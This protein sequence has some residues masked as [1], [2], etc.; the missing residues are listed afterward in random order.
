MTTQ[1]SVPKLTLWP[2]V[3]SDLL[4]VCLA[5]GLVAWSR[6]P[7][8]WVPALAATFCVF[9]G[10]WFSCQP[11][12]KRLEI[13]SKLAEHDKLA[14]TL[15]QIQSL[16]AASDLISNATTQWQSLREESQKTVL[17]ARE[18]GERMAKEVQTFNE[19]WQKTNDLEK[20][21][22]RLELEKLKRQEGDWL[23]AAIRMLDHVH[24]LFA[25]ALRSSQPTLIQ[26]LGQFQNVCRDAVRRVG[27]NVIWPESG[28]AFDPDLHQTLE[29]EDPPAG[30]GCIAEVLAAGYAFQ[31]QLV[32]KPLVR[33]K[34]ANAPE[35]PSPSDA[36]SPAPAREEVAGSESPVESASPEVEPPA[37]EPLSDNLAPDSPGPTAEPSPDA[38]PSPPVPPPGQEQELF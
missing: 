28:N 15:G 19:W 30:D 7:L 8:G 2:F 31:S 4:L 18:V 32:R 22:L 10:A 34:E 13:E 11:F 3:V 26:Q 1:T 16:R 21:Y 37:R 14:S 25:A 5:A 17:A 35:N 6:H 38:P 33:L 36:E 24:A 29:S 9:A 20:N 23:Q 27:I 12:L